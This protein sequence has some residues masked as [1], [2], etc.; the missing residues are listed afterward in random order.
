V[1]L[2]ADRGGLGNIQPSGGPLTIIFGVECGGNAPGTG[3]HTSQRRHDDPVRKGERAELERLEEDMAAR[4]LLDMSGT[5]TQLNVIR[6]KSSETKTG[7]G[8]FCM[9][10][11]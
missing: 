4:S 1:T 6:P 3:A 11:S 5:L 10:W 2:N 8:T 7:S 9:F